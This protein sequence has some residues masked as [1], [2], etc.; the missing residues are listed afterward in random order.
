M[1]SSPAFHKYAEE[2]L[3]KQLDP[4]VLEEIKDLKK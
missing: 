3:R 1:S 2:V 4:A